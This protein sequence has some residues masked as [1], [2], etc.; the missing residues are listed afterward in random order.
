MRR[1]PPLPP[2]LLPIL[3][4]TTPNKP[5]TK[6]QIRKKSF[7]H[8]Y[9]YILFLLLTIIC[10]INY[11]I[12]SSSRIVVDLD[13]WKCSVREFIDLKG[14]WNIPQLSDYVLTQYAHP[15]PTIQT[16]CNHNNIPI[17]T[18]IAFLQYT[19]DSHPHLRP[20]Y[21]TTNSLEIPQ[22][23]E[24]RCLGN[25][26]IVIVKNQQDIDEQNPDLV[27]WNPSDH[28]RAWAN[29]WCQH[30]F[31][32]PVMSHTTTTATN[33]Y[34][35]G[36]IT[37]EHLIQFPVL[38]HPLV[39]SHADLFINYHP[40]SDIPISRM[41]ENEI[42]NEF[43]YLKE[44][45]PRKKY[46]LIAIAS[47]CRN[48]WQSYEEK[49]AYYLKTI[50]KVQYQRYGNCFPEK[51]TFDIGNQ[52]KS[53][54]GGGDSYKSKIEEMKYAKFALVFENTQEIHHYVSEKLSHALLA[55]VVP[56][57]WGS[58]STI[59]ESLPSNT[60][61]IIVSGT[62]LQDNPL[63]LA[64]LLMKYNENDDLY[65]E[66]FFN[67]KKQPLPFHFKQKMQQCYLT[68]G[69]R[70]CEW[71]RKHQATVTTNKKKC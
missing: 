58:S 10:L 19:Y 65:Y 69:C 53:G 24:T 44:P 52:G 16:K 40:Q 9:Y 64:Q 8:C 11:W 49:L 39:L 68:S 37:Y 2:I 46:L 14:R 66:T 20:L 57:I 55:G 23:W 18:K 36:A 48:D 50:Y 32:D 34:F 70:L 21:A 4:T 12:L 1:P 28:G 25:C 67:W 38:A 30:P 60:S 26:E 35:L 41:C 27:I 15:K 45:F 71:V 7:S 59:Y 22:V 5:T 42:G 13:Y 31:P 63:A 51:L 6:P 56:V 47:R 61:A 54:G 43:N 3:S 33:R 17:I 62:P 29:V